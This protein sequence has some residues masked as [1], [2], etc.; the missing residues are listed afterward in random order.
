MN[1]KN[2]LTTCPKCKSK[3][4]YIDI[5]IEYASDTIVSEVKRV[6]RNCNYI[7]DY[8][9]LGVWESDEKRGSITF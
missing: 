7:I 8:W 6:C 2:G 3:E 4:S 1:N 9:C 5:P